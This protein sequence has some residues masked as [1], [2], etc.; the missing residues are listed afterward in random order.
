MR[1]QHL[2]ALRALYTSTFVGRGTEK[3]FPVPASGHEAVSQHTGWGGGSHISLPNSLTAW[4]ALGHG[5]FEAP[6]SHEVRFGRK[7]S[8]GLRVPLQASPL[9]TTKA[10]VMTS[11]CVL[12]PP[13]VQASL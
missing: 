6:L 1:E 9:C 2:S 8:L 5:C 4:R 11:S 13:T 3:Q 7:E 10:V 12:P